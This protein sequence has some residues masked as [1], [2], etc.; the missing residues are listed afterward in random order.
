M[1]H[2]A[3]ATRDAILDAISRHHLGDGAGDTRIRAALAA[4]YAAGQ[5][6][7]GDRGVHERET[8]HGALAIGRL[9]D[10]WVRGRTGDY[11]FEAKVYEEH[12]EIPAYEMGRSRISKLH[13]RRLHDDAEVYAWDRGLDRPAADAAAQAAVDAIAAGLA[14]ALYGPAGD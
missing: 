8:I 3:H 5:R 2:A 6:R 11:A 13:V 9:R 7:V 14:D 10:G 4:A 12:A 1:P